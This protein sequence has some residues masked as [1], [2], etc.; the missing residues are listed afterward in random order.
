MK[1]VSETLNK[2][3]NDSGLKASFNEALK[4]K[5]FKNFVSKIKLPIEQLMLY[6]S[7]LEESCKEYHNCENCKGL[8]ECQ[9]LVRGHAYLP[10]VKNKKIN[11]LYKGCK[12]ENKKYNDTAYLDNVYTF[13]VPDSIKKAQMKDI[14]KRDSSRFETIKWLND[15]IENYKKDKNQK[16]L[17]LHGNFGSGKTYLITAALN[18]LAKEGYKSAIVFWSEYLVELKGSFGKFNDE[19]IDLINKIKKSPILLIDD[20]GAENLTSWS[21]DDVLC[22]ILQYRMDNNLTTFITSNFDKE[23]LEKHLNFNGNEDVKARRIMERIN[24]L[25]VEMEMSSKNLRK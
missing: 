8:M 23:G 12:Y 11:F 7:L 18:E 21:R 10:E 9:N 14:Y 3:K 17:Y 20:I 5:Q 13:N 2:T 22:P 15:F 4:D 19:F 16:G 1:T 6:T 24:Q 25:T